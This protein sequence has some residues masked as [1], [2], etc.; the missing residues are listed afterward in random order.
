MKS[1]V[2]SVIRFFLILI[3]LGSLA[4]LGKRL[5]DYRTN[6]QNNKEIESIV[7]EVEDQMGS[8]ADAN[9]SDASGSMDAFTQKEQHYFKIM[10]AL[11]QK[12]NNDDIVGFID[13]PDVGI[14]YPIL[15]GPDNDFYLH[16]SISKEYDI[17]GSLFIDMNNK[18]D[19]NDDNTVIYGHHLEIN[20]MFTPLDQYRKQEFAQNH[21]TVY[22]STRDE[23]REYRIFSAYG[24]PAD[25]AYR[26][27]YFT[28]RDDV[29]PYFNQL[30]GNSEVVLPQEN[31]S[32]DDQI[33]TLS[34]C[35]YDYADQ[36]LAVHAVR[37]R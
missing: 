24:I 34:T 30:K 22:L 35:Q 25:Y 33:I 31:F 32:S 6:S 8:G 36:R 21:T 16:K 18:P 7:K 10:Q 37:V 29:V 1:K 11:E 2:M 17:A 4:I 3:I 27:L 12:Y 14:S 26:T 20:S 13:I 28:N 19:F 5:L 15:Q 23:L 9:G